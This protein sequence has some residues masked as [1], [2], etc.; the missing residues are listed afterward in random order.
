MG[1]EDMEYIFGICVDVEDFSLFQFK[2]MG[3]GY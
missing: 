3:K 1:H 2:D